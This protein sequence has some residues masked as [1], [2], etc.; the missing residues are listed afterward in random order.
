ML[1][2]LNLTKDFGGVKAVNNVSFDI[3]KGE[4][5]SIIGPN[6]AGKT[7]LFN[8]LTGL[9]KPTSG[10]IFFKNKEIVPEDKEEDIKK[11]K[12]ISVFI[13]IYSFFVTIYF[14]LVFH[15]EV[16]FP[17]EYTIFLLFVLIL[18]LFASIRLS[19]RILWAKGFLTIILF[20]DIC[21]SIYFAYRKNIILPA[22]I[23]TLLSVYFIK[24]F[25]NT[26]T[27]N[28]FGELLQLMTLLIWELQEHFK[29]SD[30]SNN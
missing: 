9:I 25:L 18:R 5:V 12:F 7:T 14:Y 30:C 11:L 15:N 16:M 29:T 22:I 17:F 24:Y 23:I 10:S 20:F 1:K 4:I 6:G 13:S 3:N 21:A 26:N 28:I 19:K 2:V 8:M 27:K